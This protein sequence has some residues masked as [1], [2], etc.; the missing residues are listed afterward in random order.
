MRKKDHFVSLKMAY[1]FALY[2]FTFL[3]RPGWPRSHRLSDEDP[4]RAWLLLH[5]HRREGDREGHQGEALLCRPRL[6]AGDGHRRQLQQPRE[7]LRASR[8]SGHHHRQ[9]EV[10]L[11]RGSLPAFLPWY[12]VLWHPRDHLQLHHEVRRRHQEGPVR[13]HRPL[14]WNHHVPR[15]RRQDAEGDHRTGSLHNEDQDHRSSREEVL[16]LD[17]RI[18]PGFSI[19]LPADV[20]L[21]TG[22]R[23]VW[24]FHC[25]QEMFLMCLCRNPHHFVLLSAF[26]FQCNVVHWSLH[27]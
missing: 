7:V 10:P 11:S 18:H 20:D 13:Q 4:H 14:R 5:H 3:L 17:R 9:R 23:R 6:R 22:V 19:H 16:R 12:G 24:T 26:L 1:V 25:P 8:R 15:Y 2:I 27:L 21:Q